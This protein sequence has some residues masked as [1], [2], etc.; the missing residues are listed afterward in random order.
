MN[1]IFIKE[2]KKFEK[3]INKNL[4]NFVNI[5]DL[6]SLYKPIQYVLSSEGK[7]LR[8]FLLYI[9]SKLYNVDDKIILPAAIAV[10]ML[11][12]FSLV[13]D[14][15]MDNDDLRRGKETIHK[16]WDQSTAILAGDAIF[17]LAYKNINEINHIKDVLKIF[18]DASIKLCE[19]QS[20]DKFF[21]SKNNILIDDYLNMI[22]LKT[23]T[24]LSLSCKLGG[25]LGKAKQDEVN[26]LGDFGNLIGTAFQIQDDILEIYSESK[27]MGKSLGSDVISSKKTFLTCYAHEFKSA[28]WNEVNYQIID[29]DLNNYTLTKLRKF[30][31]ENGIKDIAEEKIK[32]L[33]DKALIN[34]E[35]LKPGKKKYYDYYI[36]LILKRK[37]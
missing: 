32:D 9:S 22:E 4:R 26:K 19:G 8:P 37:K 17:A 2:H 24:L 25:I 14:D 31:S 10:E 21:E 27:I 18:T 20:L 36:N 23:G 3:N 34:L 16:K 15:I 1:D 12:C 7:R 5:S 6:P 30:F 33:L 28:K 11:H 29:K 13:H 35:Y